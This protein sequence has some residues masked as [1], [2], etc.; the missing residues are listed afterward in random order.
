MSS[1]FF[2]VQISAV[3][4]LRPLCKAF[5]RKGR[6]EGPQRSQRK[7]FTTEYA[8]NTEHTKSSEF[9]EVQITAV[10]GR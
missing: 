2:E 5:N 3:E 7:A 9:F 6:K 10:L 4:R 8:K 1:E